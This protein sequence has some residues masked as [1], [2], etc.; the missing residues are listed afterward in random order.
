M[1]GPT[2]HEVAKE[3]E[4]LLSIW[5]KLK[6]N[7]KQNCKQLIDSKI[8]KLRDY[9]HGIYETPYSSLETALSLKDKLVGAKF[10]LGSISLE[11]TKEME[12]LMVKNGLQYAE[13]AEVRKTCLVLYLVTYSLNYNRINLQL[14]HDSKSGISRA[15]TLRHL[16]VQKQHIFYVTRKKRLAWY[17]SITGIAY[18]RFKKMSRR[19]LE[20]V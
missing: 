1:A 15:N 7:D 2:R 16:Q 9:K 10:D 20:R 12:D 17:I 11:I 8:R 5:P 4:K 19:T 18:I 6:D 3:V 13:A 14:L